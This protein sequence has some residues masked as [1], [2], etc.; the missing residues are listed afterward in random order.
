MDVRCHIH[1]HSRAVSSSC[2]L[3][4]AGLRDTAV[5]RGRVEGTKMRPPCLHLSVRLTCFSPVLLIWDGFYHLTLFVC[6]CSGSLHVGIVIS[7]SRDKLDFSDSQGSLL[8]LCLPSLPIWLFHIKVC[9]VIHFHLDFNWTWT[10]TYLLKL[11]L[12]AIFPERNGVS[13]TSDNSKLVP[14]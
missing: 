11:S 5:Q 2:K 14:L 6:I 13:F 3:G 7:L 1:K 8:C 4:L 12:D 9:K 10:T